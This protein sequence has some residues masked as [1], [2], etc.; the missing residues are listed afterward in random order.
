[1]VLLS[2][3]FSVRSRKNFEGLVHYRIQLLSPQKTKIVNVCVIP[4][5][6]RKKAK[7]NN[8]F[9][10][11]LLTEVIFVIGQSHHF[12]PILII[13]DPFSSHYS[14]PTVKTPGDIN[15]CRCCRRFDCVGAGRALLRLLLL[16]SLML[17]PD[18]VFCFW[19]SFIF[20]R[21]VATATFLSHKFNK[22]HMKAEFNQ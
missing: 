3:T 5:I 7:E 15:F 8:L 20:I 1:M 10:N 17:T 14:H 16:L 2:G 19:S 22:I 12:W 13:F 18:K 4:K 9:S 11:L 6:L 21:T